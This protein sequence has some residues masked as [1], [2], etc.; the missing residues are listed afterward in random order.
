MGGESDNINVSFLLLFFAVQLESAVDKQHKHHMEKQSKQMKVSY[1]IYSPILW[2][3]QYWIV[4]DATVNIIVSK[5]HMD[6]P[7]SRCELYTSALAL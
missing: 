3:Q 2:C 7:H 6:G 1:S 4:L 5:H